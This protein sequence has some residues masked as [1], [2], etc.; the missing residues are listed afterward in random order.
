M[1]P[2]LH[3]FA[4]ALIFIFSSIAF[5]QPTSQPTDDLQSRRGSFHISFTEQSPLSPI[6]VQNKRHHIKIEDNEKYDLSQESFEMFVPDDFDPK[7]AYGLFV[8]VNAGNGGNMPASWQA[9]LAKHQLIGIGANNSGNFRPVGV[10]FGLALDATYNI[11]KKFNI[12][13]SRVYLAGASGGGKVVSMLAMIYPE[14]FSGA[15]PMVGVAYFHSIDVI[16]DPTKAYAVMF[17]RPPTFM[18]DRA[19]QQSRFVLITGSND[20]NRDPVK[21]TY[22]EG[23]VPDGFQ[24]VQYVEVPGMGHQPPDAPVLDQAIETLDEPLV[25]DAPKNFEK[26]QA[27]EKSGKISEARPLY[28]E[29]AAHGAQPLAQQAQQRLLDLPLN[30]K[31]I[32]AVAPPAVISKP[33]EPTA[34]DDERQAQSLYSLAEN[35]QRNKMYDRAQQKLELLLKDHPQSQVAAKAKL[36]LDQLKSRQQ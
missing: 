11:E 29:V 6:E 32:P 23:F 34:D 33:V 9:I 35:Y 22:Q 15:I 17:D 30:D 36:L 27:L 19:K 12:D 20:M 7:K 8:W 21:A 13:A 3:H 10:R 18:L 25:S 14:V 4:C 24:H 1:T 28:A 5:A 16:G 26:A 2:Q 31:P